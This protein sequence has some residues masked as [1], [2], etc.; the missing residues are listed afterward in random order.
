MAGCEIAESCFQLMLKTQ[1]DKKVIYN[2]KKQFNITK[3]TS[4]HNFSSYPDHLQCGT[5]SFIFVK[6]TINGILFLCFAVLKSVKISFEVISEIP[7]QQ[8]TME[9]FSYK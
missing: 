4:Y 6:A 8:D 1:H 5:V 2:I 7:V 9:L 3:F